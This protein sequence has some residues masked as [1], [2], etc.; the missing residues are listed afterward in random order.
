MTIKEGKKVVGKGSLKSGK[1]TITLSKSKLGKGKSKLKV[2]WPGN[3]LA[4]GSTKSFT[5]TVKK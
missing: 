2:S 4:S 5:V 3:A 1:A